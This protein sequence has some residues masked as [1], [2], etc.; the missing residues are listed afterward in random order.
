MED[1]AAS[2][3]DCPPCAAAASS[4]LPSRGLRPRLLVIPAVATLL[5][6]GLVLSCLG[7]GSSPAP[8]PF[9]T[10]TRRLRSSARALSTPYWGLSQE[11]GSDGRFRLVPLA[12]QHASQPSSTTPVALAPAAPVL[13][14]PAPAPREPLAPLLPGV[15]WTVE[16]VPYYSWMW[17]DAAERPAPLD[18][19][20]GGAEPEETRW[21][22]WLSRA[23]A[24]EDFEVYRTE[25][26]LGRPVEMR[27]AAARGDSGAIIPGS[28]R[29]LSTFRNLDAAFD[30]LLR[31]GAVLE[32]PGQE[33]QRSRGGDRDIDSWG[34]G[35]DDRRDDRHDDRHDHDGD[36]DEGGWR[37]QAAPAGTALSESTV[38]STSQPALNISSAAAPG[39][40][41]AATAE[42]GVATGS[43][44]SSLSGTDGRLAGGKEQGEA[45]AAGTHI[46]T[47]MGYLGYLGFIPCLAATGWL[48]FRVWHRNSC[49]ARAA[50]VDEETD[51]SGEDDEPSAPG[52]ANPW[53]AFMGAP[54]EGEMRRLLFYAEKGPQA[55]PPLP[56]D[57]GIAF[58]PADRPLAE[59]EVE[60]ILAPGQPLQ[61]F[62]EGDAG[63]RETEFRRLVRLLHPDSGLVPRERSMLALR[64]VVEAYRVAAGDR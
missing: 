23:A 4:A 61:L 64:R 42:P 27:I 41:E 7:R 25:D 1:P 45:H 51:S 35:I 40:T 22:A 5:A 43:G 20:H 34:L 29:F 6:G 8:G 24:M 59:A 62:A 12:S 31:G 50:D 63:A 37:S 57:N 30:Y 3:P 13:A 16:P 36:D 32:F 11:Q 44:S 19:G 17:A 21:S 55:L 54:R 47:T 56:E 49:R 15:A 52:A 26:N 18:I 2:I 9:G 14:P 38:G 39:Q 33:E 28:K 10:A 58:G 48:A 53:Q 60:R 46:A